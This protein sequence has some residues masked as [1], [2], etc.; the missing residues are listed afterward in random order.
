MSEFIARSYD[1]RV[2]SHQSSVVFRG[3]VQGSVPVLLTGTVCHIHFVDETTKNSA[4]R[5]LSIAS[6]KTQGKDLTTNQHTLSNKNS[7][8]MSRIR[9]ASIVILLT[10]PLELTGEFDSD[11]FLTVA[12]SV[13]RNSIPC[14][15]RT[16]FF[17]STVIVVCLMLF[18]LAIR[19]LVDGRVQRL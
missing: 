9:S 12:V 1:H 4:S 15:P 19:T 10:P 14:H 13:S 2:R 7:I 17:C 16:F 11:R 3:S 18:L 6:T 5:L 8:R